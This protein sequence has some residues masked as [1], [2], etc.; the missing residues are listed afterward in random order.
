MELIVGNK[1]YSSWSFRPWIAL[2][3]AEISFEERVVPFTE[4]EGENP[5]Y[6]E[7]SPSLRVPVLIDNGQQIWDSLA[8]LEYLAEQYPEKAL[9]PI[10]VENRARARSL[11]CEMHAG[12]GDLRTECPMNMRRKIGRISVSDGVRR[13]V[14]RIEHMWGECL[15]HSG[16][17]F[18]FGKFTNADAMYAPVVNRIEIYELSQADSVKAY[19]SAM[20]ALPAWKEWAEAGKSEPWIVDYDEA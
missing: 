18:L 8:I 7:F 20:K 5:Q 11:A 15:D 2:K 3:T 13:D 12:F 6:A 9:W 19:T 14:G 16:G 10:E 4:T 17:P 1:N